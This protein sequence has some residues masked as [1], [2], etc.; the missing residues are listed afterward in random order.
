MKAQRGFTLVELM[1]TL[2]IV[3]LVLTL[4]VPTFQE[5]FRNYRVTSLT[6]QFFTSLNLARST[7]IKEN[8][9]AVLLKF[10]TSVTPVPGTLPPAAGGFERG[11]IVFADPNNNATWEAG[12]TLIQVFEP[13]ADTGVTIQGNTA[14]VADYV[15]FRPDGM[16]RLTTGIMQMGKIIICKRPKALQIIISTGRIRMGE[17]SC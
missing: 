10:D 9:R 12:E 16:P 11:W 6:N 15:S 13:V 8:V 3:A 2:A 7:A 4:G 17:T 1:I 14:N 5:S